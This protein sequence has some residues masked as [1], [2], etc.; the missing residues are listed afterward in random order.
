M[1]LLLPF[2]LTLLVLAPASAH[3]VCLHAGQATTIIEGV[4]SEGTFMDANDQPEKAFILTPL[5]PTC[6]IGDENIDASTQVGT[7][8]IFSSNDQVAQILKNFVGK[9]VFV[10]GAPFGAHT[11]HHH[12]PIVMDIT[13]IQ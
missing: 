11:T 7:V 9:D 2:A 1:R 8:Q 5:L 13:G 12:A 6:L 3:A 10:Q 4:L